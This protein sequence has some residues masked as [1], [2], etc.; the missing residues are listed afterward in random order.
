VVVS[1]FDDSLIYTGVDK[2]SLKLLVKVA[3]WDPSRMKPVEGM[4]DLLNALVRQKGNEAKPSAVVFYISGG[5]V[6]FYPRILAFLEKEAYPRGPLLLRNWGT[7]N[8]GELETT[9]RF[10]TSKIEELMGLFKSGKFI[11]IGDNT[12]NDPEIYAGLRE[13]H[14]DRVEAIMIRKVEEKEERNGRFND[15]DLICDGCEALRIAKEK[16]IIEDGE[17][18]RKT[19]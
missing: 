12:E 4:R 15:M 9:V 11:L 13:K 7:N 19:P 6:N 1:D 2:K 14:P 8:E 18:K 16:G 3:T 17:I 5:P 10:K